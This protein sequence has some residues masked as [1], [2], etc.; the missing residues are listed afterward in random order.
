MKIKFAVILISFVLLISCTSGGQQQ[1]HAR[2]QNIDDTDSRIAELLQEI[3]DHLRERPDHADRH[4]GTCGVPMGEA[5][6]SFRN[7]IEG[8]PLEV[9]IPFLGH[10][11]PYLRDAVYRILYEMGDDATQAIHDAY[12]N[13]DARIKYMLLRF[14]DAEA[15]ADAKYSLLDEII[16]DEN[17]PV[18]FE[19]YYELVQIMRTENNNVCLVLESFQNYP[20]DIYT[21]LMRMMKESDFYPD[22]AWAARMLGTFGD[23]AVGAILEIINLF[24]LEDDYVTPMLGGPDNLS[25][26]SLHGAAAIALGDFGP[27]ASDAI[28][29]LLEALNSTETGYYV[30]YVR[31]HSASSLYLIGHDP[32]MMVQLLV[33]MIQTTDT[34]D[35]M[36]YQL[37]GDVEYHLARIGPDAVDAVPR[38]TELVDH[39]HHWVNYPARNAISSIE[40]SNAT[41]IQLLINQLSST[42]LEQLNFAVNNLCYYR[43]DEDLEPAILVLLNVMD[44][45]HDYYLRTLC[46]RLFRYGGLEDEVTERIITEIETRHED[47]NEV[48]GVLR[49]MGPSASAA[50]PVLQDLIMDDNE[51]T[52][53]SSAVYAFNAIGGDAG[54]IVPRLIEVLY[55]DKTTYNADDV[56][57]WALE[58]LGPAA[59]D[60]LPYLYEIAE[61]GDER[62][63]MYIDR[64]IAAIEGTEEES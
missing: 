57:M 17:L 11:A 41:A 16:Q 33:D 10:T 53:L 58:D 26:H 49:Q 12:E 3:D 54:Q 20:V 42:D 38:L 51:I 25:N 7:I 23:E 59:S 28:P 55:W 1:V 63:A 39:E 40:G 60:A 22:K 18:F 13:G 56:A 27:A 34:T 45:I 24:Q 6:E 44:Q 64:A 43:D 46:E 19:D 52:N 36:K 14:V 8:H 29:V 61:S 21:Y 35:P 15:M 30:E 31:I 37:V 32:D 9:I 62:K 47:Y 48:L 5:V 50:I 2:P 4:I